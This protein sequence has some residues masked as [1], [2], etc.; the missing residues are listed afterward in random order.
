[1]SD[2]GILFAILTYIKVKS[3]RVFHCLNHDLQ[4]THGCHYCFMLWLLSRSSL[5]STT[6]SLS[7]L[8]SKQE[9]SEHSNSLTDFNPEISIRYIFLRIPYHCSELSI[10]YHVAPRSHPDLF[11]QQAPWLPSILVTQWL[12]Q[13]NFTGMSYPRSPPHH[14]HKA[15]TQKI[16][17]CLMVLPLSVQETFLLPALLPFNA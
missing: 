9:P 11:G 4:S 17:S 12:P 1:M 8:L 16:Y 15:W 13:G 2:G 6:S 7:N 14:I 3:N 5:C 10:L